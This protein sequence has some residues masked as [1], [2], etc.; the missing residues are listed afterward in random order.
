MDDHSNTSSNEISMAVNELHTLTQEN[1]PNK[2]EAGPQ[3]LFV[4]P[5]STIEP[6]YNVNTNRGFA[7]TRSISDNTTP[8][9]NVQLN[10]QYC[11]KVSFNFFACN[12]LLKT[13]NFQTDFLSNITTNCTQHN[14]PLKNASILGT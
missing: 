10:S 8:G 12:F 4:F 5:S 2:D 11:S 9:L 3:K 7:A 6:I 13:S 1:S 14:A